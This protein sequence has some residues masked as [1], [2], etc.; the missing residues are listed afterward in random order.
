MNLPQQDV[1][2]AIATPPGKGGVGII[3]VTG[4][5]LSPILAAITNTDVQAR[6]AHLLDFL[7][8]DGST[9]DT[10]IA[11]FFPA[12]NSYTGEDTLELQGHGSPVVLGML[13]RRLTSLGVRLANPGEFTQRAFLNNKIDLAQAEAIADL[14]DSSTEQAARSAQKSMQGLFSKHIHLLIT[15]LIDLRQYVEASIDFSEEAIDFLSDGAVA[16]KLNTVR[17]QLHTILQSAQQGCLLRDGMNVVIIGPPNVGKSTLLNALSGEDMAIVSEIV[18]TTRDTLRTQIQIDGMPLHIIDTAGLR[19]A[20]DSIEQEGIRRA[21]QEIA[22]ADLLLM[23]NDGQND[24]MADDTIENNRLAL[25]IPDSI[26]V[27]RIHT[28]IDQLNQPA[29]LNTDH[30]ET[31]ISLSAKSGEGLDLLR[32]YLKQS[33]GYQAETD[34]IFIA[35]RRHTKALEEALAA[36]ETG[37]QYLSEKQAI[38]LLAEELR[39]AQNTLNEITGEF[40]NEDLLGEIFSSFC[41]GK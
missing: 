38:E 27:C 41:I 24:L 25:S 35:R 4:S 17:S 5:D 7:D 13:L 30:Q 39:I 28:K 9:I 34:D 18:G 14:I 36:I 32:N 33:M 26:P 1:I 6:H 10:G 23:L 16:E 40:T 19:Q 8:Q 12:P 20:T 11:L 29:A 37:Q 21:Y 2:A 31:H 15:Q 3:R 22:N